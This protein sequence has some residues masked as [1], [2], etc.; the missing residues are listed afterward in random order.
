MLTRLKE[1]KKEAGKTE[2]FH[3]IVM[4][5]IANLNAPGVWYGFLVFLVP[6]LILWYFDK[7]VTKW[8]NNEK[9]DEEIQ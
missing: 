9:T 4:I 6:Y 2:L 7:P 5:L 1:M 8:M 3:L